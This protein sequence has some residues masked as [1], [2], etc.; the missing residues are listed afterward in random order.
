MQM[1]LNDPPDYDGQV[2]ELLI[3]KWIKRRRFIPKEG[4]ALT[5]PIRTKVSRRGNFTI[6]RLLGNL[7]DIGIG[8]TKRN[9]TDNWHPSTGIII[10]TWRALDDA[11]K[12]GELQ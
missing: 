9:P 1:N 2:G 7:G 4:S 12:R 11:H 8:A 6:V 10:A 5:K 3:K